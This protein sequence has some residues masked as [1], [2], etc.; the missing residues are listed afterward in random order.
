MN[1][2]APIPSD[3]VFHPP[4]SSIVSPSSK[5]DIPV[6]VVSL[7]FQDKM[8][9]SVMWRCLLETTDPAGAAGLTASS[10]VVLAA[11]HAGVW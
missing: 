5:I 3:S 10:L 11:E 1:P 8:Y 9:S 7:A 4:S 6:Q 2:P